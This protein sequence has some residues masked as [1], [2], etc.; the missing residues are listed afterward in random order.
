MHNLPRISRV[1]AAI[2]EI[3]ESGERA[4]VVML[5]ARLASYRVLIT[6]RARTLRSD[7]LLQSAEASQ[8]WPT[9]DGSGG[10]VRDRWISPRE[11]AARLNISMRTLRRRAGR[12]PYSA[13]CIPQPERGFKVSEQALE[14]YM[15]RERARR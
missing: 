5:L 8:R 1:A 2:E 13:F 11:C 6:E 10:S 12:P 3:I 4:E 14:D 9:G 15:R 7:P